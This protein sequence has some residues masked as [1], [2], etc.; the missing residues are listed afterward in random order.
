VGFW[1]VWGGEGSKF[2][3][4]KLGIHGAFTGIPFKKLIKNSTKAS[5]KLAR[6]TP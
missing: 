1:S 4:L 2:K 5:T 6:I 3:H